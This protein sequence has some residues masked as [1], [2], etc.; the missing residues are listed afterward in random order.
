MQIFAAVL[1]L[2]AMR[3]GA[4]PAPGLKAC[5][6]PGEIIVAGSARD[7]PLA[8]S[9][10]AATPRPQTAVRSP[11]GEWSA[12]EDTLDPSHPTLLVWRGAAR[13]SIRMVA[14]DMLQGRMITGRWIGRDLLCV[15]SSFNPAA[16]ATW[17]VDVR[18]VRVIARGSLQQPR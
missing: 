9:R 5:A 10:V 6:R 11:S 16:I 15:E 17:L 8:I 18:Q 14:T 13:K 2:T 1:L 3:A 7:L 4:P 12:I